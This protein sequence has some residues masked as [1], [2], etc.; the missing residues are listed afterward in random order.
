MTSEDTSKTKLYLRIIFQLLCDLHLLSHEAK[1]KGNIVSKYVLK[2][3]IHI[4][5]LNALPNLEIKLHL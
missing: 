2:Y 1:T 3:I 5:I 4:Y